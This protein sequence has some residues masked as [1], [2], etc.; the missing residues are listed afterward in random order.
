MLGEVVAHELAA[1]SFSR[2]VGLDTGMFRSPLGSTRESAGVSTTG[3]ACEA[4]GDL[5]VSLLC[6]HSSAPLHG[7]SDAWAR[8]TKK[9]LCLKCLVWI[10]VAAAAKMGIMDRQTYP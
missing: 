1:I 6:S 5:R 2:F 7:R 10:Q 3:T 4:L 8:I 9:L